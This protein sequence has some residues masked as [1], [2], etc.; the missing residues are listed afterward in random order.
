[1]TDQ[2]FYAIMCMCHL[3]GQNWDIMTSTGKY[4]QKLC[5]KKEQHNN[6]SYSTLFQILLI[7]L[8]I[9]QLN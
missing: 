7:L 3:R 5:C 6:Q 1:M 9:I 2:K 8:Y 4:L